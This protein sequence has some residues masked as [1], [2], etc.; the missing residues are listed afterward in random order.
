MTILVTNLTDKPLEMHSFCG[1]SV[2]IG[3]KAKKLSVAHI[4]HWKYDEGLRIVEDLGPDDSCPT[5]TVRGK[6]VLPLARPPRTVKEAQEF[7]LA[8]VPAHATASA[9]EEMARA[10]KEALAKLPQ[11]D[12]AA[13]SAA[14]KTAPSVAGNKPPVAE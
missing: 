10:A 8:G 7:H 11:K 5:A 2:T 6:P 9:R 13:S 12:G 14:L 3:A 4:F 1:N